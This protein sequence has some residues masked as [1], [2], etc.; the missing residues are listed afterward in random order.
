M[1]ELD[2]L[3]GA[4][5]IVRR[6]TTLN[7]F[8]RAFVRW[9]CAIL[10][11][12]GLAL[13]LS[14]T[15][16]WAV[17]ASG[18]LAVAGTLASLT[19]ALRGRLS[20]YEAAVQLDRAS[21]LDDR[22]STAFFFS[23]IKT[24][25][26]IVVRQREDAIEHLARLNPR[27]LF[28]VLLPAGARAGLLLLLA[29]GALC[30][31]RMYSG[32]PLLGLLRKAGE[33]RLVKAILSPI[34]HAMERERPAK[35]QLQTLAE[36]QENETRAGGP[37]AEQAD[38]RGASADGRSDAREQK[39]AAH[40]DAQQR[41]EKQEASS[42]QDGS[43]ADEGQLERQEGQQGS[44]QQGG[45][46]GQSRENRP[47]GRQQV[48]AAASGDQ[49]QSGREQQEGQSGSESAANRS[50]SLA[51]T[52]MQALKNLLASVTGAQQAQSR[53]QTGQNG[54]QG[55]P[56]PQA[57]NSGH[58]APQPSAGNQRANESA[59]NAASGLQQPGDHKAGTGV[60]QQPGSEDG[61]A[62]ELPASTLLADR[63]ALQ[64]QEFSGE[65][66]VRARPGQ[67]TAQSAAGDG[68]S[69]SAASVSGAEQENV[70]LRYRLY[71][72]RYFDHTVKGRK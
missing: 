23:R 32:P 44:E 52:V 48:A 15:L 16:T 38:S 65:A 11:G 8:L 57:G 51:R 43:S 29:A 30:T 36:L 14:S 71:L 35:E 54:S 69:P 60:G 5:A 56:Q 10:S 19:R 47:G 55:T 28:P 53:G 49:S 27:A 70:P 1:A 3:V 9:A 68:A 34:A 18:V 26:R 67:G 46:E 62:G 4:L 6:R 37:D 61:K 50:Q 41:Q 42:N 45:A 31:Y 24:P 58:R 39:G 21:A 63:V 17:M 13:A 59:S 72:R 12:L 64:T 20:L 33:T 25:D 66:L 22:L 2:T 40:R 7:R